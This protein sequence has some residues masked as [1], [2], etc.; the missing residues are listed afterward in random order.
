MKRLP[1]ITSL[2]LKTSF[3]VRRPHAIEFEMNWDIF[4]VMNGQTNHE[5]SLLLTDLMYVQP[6]LANSAS[7]YHQRT[8][9]FSRNITWMYFSTFKVVTHAHLSLSSVL[10]LVKLFPLLAKCSKKKS[11]TTEG[12]RVNHLTSFTEK[13]ILQSSETKMLNNLQHFKTNSFSS[14]GI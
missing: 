12:Q 7:I 11:L 3:S 5:R 2:L 10:K 14:F 4:L 9:M 13:R 1:C 8:E 6:I